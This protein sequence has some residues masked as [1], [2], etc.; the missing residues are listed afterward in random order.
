MLLTIP[1]WPSTGGLNHYAT[2]WKLTRDLQ[3]K[4]VELLLTED[5]VNLLA[6][7]NTTVIPTGAVWYISALRHL[8]DAAGNIV[9]NSKWIGPKPIIN[10][11]SNVNDYLAPEFTISKPY[12]KSL[13]YNPGTGLEFTL[14]PVDGNVGYKNTLVTITDSGKN[15][16]INKVVDLTTSQSFNISNNEVN[17]ALHNTIQITI[18]NIGNHST[19]SAPYVETINLKDVYY[20]V[21]GNTTNL[22]PRTLNTLVF[23]NK[24]SVPVTIVSADILN[25]NGDLIDNCTVVNS[26]VT[27]PLNLEFGESYNMYTTLSYRNSSNKIVTFNESVYVTIRNND[28]EILVDSNFKYKNEI[29]KVKEFVL[30]SQDNKIDTAHLFNSEEFFTNLTPVPSTSGDIDLFIFD[31][32]TNLFNTAKSAFYNI[33]TNFSIRLFTK[34]NGV[35]QIQNGSSLELR[36]FKYDSYK[37]TMSL[38]HTV[39]LPIVGY[40][41]EVNKICY[42]GGKFYLTGV[43]SSNKKNILIYEVN[44]STGG[45]TLIH[46]ESTT[47]SMSDLAV[48]PYKTDSLIIT[49]VNGSRLKVFNVSTKSFKDSIAIPSNFISKHQFSTMLNNGNIF[50]IR[51]NEISGVLDFFIIDIYNNIIITK[52][53]PYNSGG[54][55]RNMIKLKNGSILL[56]IANSTKKMIFEL[57]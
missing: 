25:L 28:E 30:S 46:T 36:F 14:I 17:F 55:I 12:I 19:I 32:E 5:T 51:I 29:I 38:I 37:D 57:V 2:T 41:P 49:P 26:N 15:T 44:I 4:Q 9:N 1:K 23:E 27:L 24:T 7:E 50:N 8:K 21:I 10:D 47:V 53:V 11:N 35:I 40:S 54:S 43:S 42:V 56:T 48:A 45:T 6:L 39:A 33:N 52:S 22:D 13:N 31:K 34:T 18:I 20:R 3:G 16:L